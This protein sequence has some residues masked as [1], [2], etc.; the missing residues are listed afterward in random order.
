MGVRLGDGCRVLAK[1]PCPRVEVVMGNYYCS[2]DAWVMEL[3]GV[4]LILRVAWLKTLGDVVHNW[5]NMTMQFYNEGKLVEFRGHG[6][7]IERNLSFRSLVGTK[8]DGIQKLN[9]SKALK[10]EE[11][12]LI[13]AEIQEKELT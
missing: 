11:P 3:G 10:E 7:K 8:M 4:D 6:C 5:D 9:Y 12:D 1:G 2:V 13:L